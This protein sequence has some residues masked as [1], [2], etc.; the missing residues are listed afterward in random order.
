MNEDPAARLYRL[1]LRAFSRE[2]RERY[3]DELVRVFGEA[4]CAVRRAG[5]WAALEYQ[6]R[7]WVD[8]A[9]SA[10]HERFSSMNR[11]TIVL[12][13]AAVACGLLATWVD[14]HAT[15]VQATLLVFLVTSF[16]LGVAG[17]KG[18]WRWA[19][20]VAV[21][22]PAAQMLAFALRHAGPASA[23]PY[24]SRL[25]I[26]LPALGACLLGAYAGA[27]VRLLFRGAA[28]PTGAGPTP[29]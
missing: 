25:A 14:F 6:A 28:R 13:P 4:R 26:L 29:E 5:P 16:I 12:A 8:L 24:W 1:G 17:P 19:L 15:E 27:L 23:H 11:T 7:V 22:L 3:A 2:F 10:G 21:W 18:A 20:V 9:V